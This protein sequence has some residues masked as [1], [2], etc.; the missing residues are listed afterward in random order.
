MRVCKAN[1]PISSHRP[2]PAA[3]HTT[4]LF[5]PSHILRA[6]ERSSGLI[7]LMG[8]L[9]LLLLRR[10]T[11][12]TT[13]AA[14]T[15]AEPIFTPFLLLLCFPPSFFIPRDQAGRDNW[16]DIS[17]SITRR[18]P[19]LCSGTERREREDEIISQGGLTPYFST[20]LHTHYYPV[21]SVVSN[22]F[23]FT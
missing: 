7:V 3:T 15:H 22:M 4:T 18:Q 2:P 23:S 19:L 20:L 11:T 8:D 5:H 21:Q 17:N 9:G 12:T 6:R 10:T 13:A 14:S 1:G 16:G